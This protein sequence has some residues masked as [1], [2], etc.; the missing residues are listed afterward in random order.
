[1]TRGEK[2]KIFSHSA[3]EASSCLA[4]LSCDDTQTMDSWGFENVSPEMPIVDWT[5]F[6]STLFLLLIN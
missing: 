5:V 6:K 4:R 1:M 2:K 3:E